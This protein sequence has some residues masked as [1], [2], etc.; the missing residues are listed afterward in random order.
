[1]F[2]SEYNTGYVFYKRQVEQFGVDLELI[3]NLSGFRHDFALR[4]VAEIR[5]KVGGVG[6]EFVD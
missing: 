2:E 6:A 3:W 5:H 1:M 4:Q